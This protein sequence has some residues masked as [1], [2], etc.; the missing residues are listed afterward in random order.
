MCH[1]STSHQDLKDFFNESALAS[2][3]DL[4]D[5]KRM[6]NPNN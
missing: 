1:F 5:D 6:G 3:L 4:E 2:V